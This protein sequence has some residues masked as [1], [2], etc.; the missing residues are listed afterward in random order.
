MTI[1]QAQSSAVNI[2]YP[3]VSFL[4]VC[5]CASMH[6]GRCCLF[7]W[8]LFP[9]FRQ[10]FSLIFQSERFVMTWFN[11]MCS[12][13]TSLT[14]ISNWFPCF[15]INFHIFHSDTIIS[16]IHYLMITNLMGIGDGQGGL[17]CCDSWGRKESDTTERLNW[18]EFSGI[19]YNNY[20]NIYSTFVESYVMFPKID[21]KVF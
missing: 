9:W 6:V 19:S 10:Q 11:V 16:Q 17:G 8:K 4:F 20:F 2:I 13:Q 12:T 21:Y 3:K 14:V 15:H 18:T 1:D 7:P 5:T